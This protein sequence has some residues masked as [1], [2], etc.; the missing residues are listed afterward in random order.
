MT[1]TLSQL[2]A[3]DRFARACDM[4]ARAQAEHLSYPTP[5]T[6]KAVQTATA[7]LTRARKDTG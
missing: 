6:E 2:E 1:Q 4:L 3:N 7:A 5:E